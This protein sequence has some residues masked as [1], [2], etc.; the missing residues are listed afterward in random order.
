M[1]KQAQKTQSP[2][3]SNLKSGNFEALLTKEQLR[4]ITG[5][6]IQMIDKCRKV[7]G[8]PSYK[9]GELVRFRLSE[10]N[11]WLSQRRDVGA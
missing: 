11:E 8:M 7:W 10:V 6:D 9:I 3:P 5:L 2:S 1:P 4:D